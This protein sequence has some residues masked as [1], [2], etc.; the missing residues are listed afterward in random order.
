MLIITANHEKAEVMP[1]PETEFHKLEN[2]V[3]T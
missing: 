1:L 3:V 2:A